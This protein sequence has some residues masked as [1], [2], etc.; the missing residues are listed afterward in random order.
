MP[1]DRRK[2]RDDEDTANE[3]QDEGLG[4]EENEITSDDDVERDTWSPLRE[5]RLK[6]SLRE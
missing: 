4:W 2:S 5:E 1:A 3:R 6:R